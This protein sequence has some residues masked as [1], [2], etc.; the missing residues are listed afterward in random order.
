MLKRHFQ[1]SWKVDYLNDSSYGWSEDHGR[2][3]LDETIPF[4]YQ[5]NM[6]H[7]N[8][9]WVYGL[10]VK[11]FFSLEEE[12]KRSMSMLPSLGRPWNGG[13]GSLIS[14]LLIHVPLVFLFHP[15]KK[16]ATPF[17]LCLFLSHVHPFLAATLALV[18]ALC[19]FVVALKKLHKGEKRKEGKEKKG[20]SNP[21]FWPTKVWWFWSHPLNL[22]EN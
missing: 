20:C 3:E 14:S 15:L 7:L 5:C 2:V 11:I 4:Y 1:E 8:I 10:M 18:S 9:G 17:S 22:D 6:F 19:W 12:K 16:Q 21:R 13:V